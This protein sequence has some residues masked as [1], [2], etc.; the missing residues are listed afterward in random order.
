MAFATGGTER[1]RIDTGGNLLV[2]K[3]ANSGTTLGAQMNA[4]GSVTS[5]RTS[6]SNSDLTWFTWSIGAG[7]A[8]FYVGMGGTVYA[9]STSISAI[10]DQSLKENVVDIEP[11]LDKVMSLRPIR[12]DWKPEMQIEQKQIQGFIAQDIEQV[13][14]DLVYDYQYNQTEVKKSIKMGDMIPTLVKAIQEQQ[15]IITNLKSRIE[16]LEAKNDTI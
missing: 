3:T 7:A 9:T 1:M 14:P 10:S 6:S 15:A 4:D 2:G 13:L 5:A 16:A 12:F 11:S 8:R